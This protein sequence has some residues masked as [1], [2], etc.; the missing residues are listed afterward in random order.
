MTQRRISSYQSACFAFPY[1]THFR[2]MRFVAQFMVI[3][4]IAHVMGLVLPWY[5]CVAVAFIAGY[6]LKSRRN[7]L[8]GFMALAVL[9]TFNAWLADAA[10]SST[11]P[12]R[13]AQILGLHSV[14]MGLFADG[15]GGRSGWWLRDNVG[16]DAEC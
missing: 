14:G 3:V 16:R 15:C 1:V 5:A 2:A 10:S 11:L 4:V 13:V 8:A 12:L 7:F 6:F 9:W